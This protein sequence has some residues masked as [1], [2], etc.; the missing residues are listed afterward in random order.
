MLNNNCNICVVLPVLKLKITG[1]VDHMN[2]HNTILRLVIT[3]CFISL[4]GLAIA[5]C[6]KPVPKAD[7]DELKAR[8]GIMLKI[9]SSVQIAVDY[10]DESSFLGS[11]CEIYW[12]GTIIRT[13]NYVNSQT[14]VKGTTDLTPEDYMSVYNFAEDVMDGETYSFIYFPPDRSEGVWLYA[15]YCYG[16]K[17][18]TDILDLTD[19]YFK[20]TE[21]EPTPTP[22]PDIEELKSRSGT[23]LTVSKDNSGL[24]SI[25]D[26]H[27]C[28]TI[29]I[30]RWNGEISSRTTYGK[31]NKG[32]WEYK[33]LS[34]EDYMIMFDFARE[35]YE[36]GT[37]ESY[38]EANGEYRWRFECDLSEGGEYQIYYGF[39]EDN[40]GL[41]VISGIVSS[42][43]E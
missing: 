29:Y 2:N 19:S 3:V 31:D 23:M 9:G 36:N 27:Y 11:T 1:G 12:D 5:G 16:N 8:E 39:I 34:D 25:Y 33:K 43:F 41:S 10:T 18:L 40:N 21:S 37:F 7:I 15:G 26:D 32:E 4:L 38:S 14:V 42:Y 28:S 17:K 6:R 22:V 24:Y 30:I 35:A 13:L 20:N